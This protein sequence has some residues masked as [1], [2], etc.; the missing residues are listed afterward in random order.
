[1]FTH[2]VL[3]TNNIARSRAFYDAVMGVLGYSNVMPPDAPRLAYRGGSCA[4]VITPPL[5]G[6]PATY[7]NGGTVGLY[8]ASDAIVDA[9]H[10][11]GLAHGGTDEGAPGKRVN[12]PGQSY[13]AYLR[14]P[15]GNKL[16]CYHMLP[17]KL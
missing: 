14:D 4:L 16:C 13:G 7:A 8:A 15:D 9:W 5:N 12:S 3:G 6:E 10:Q 2:I 11:A 1:M 17:V